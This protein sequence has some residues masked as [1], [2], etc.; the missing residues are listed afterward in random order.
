MTRSKLRKR[1]EQSFG[2]VPDP[3]YY[4]GDM[5]YIRAYSDYRRGTDCSTAFIDDITWHDLDMD[6]VYRRIN[7]ALST[8]GEQY[9]YG[10]SVFFDYRLRRGKA[11]TRN[12]INLLHMLGFDNSIVSGAHERAN[13]YLE[14]GVWQ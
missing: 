9:L 14:N 11:M 2:K 13:R 4:S 1:L 12:A 5:E 6:R 3:H 10:E 7:P 8:S